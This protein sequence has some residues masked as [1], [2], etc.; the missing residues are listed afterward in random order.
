LA[1]AGAQTLRIS[2]QGDLL[3]QTAGG[4]LRQHR[5]VVYQEV[6][7]VR[8]PVRGGYV[9][10]GKNQIG[11]QVARYDATR[12][13]VIDPTFSYST[14][15]GGSNA[16]YAYGIAVDTAGSAYVTGYTWSTDFPGTTASNNIDAFV[17]KL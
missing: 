4:T 1:I 6:D 15:L 12:P 16:D 14:Y 2:P 17:T 8:R 11:F 7:G 5:P 13:L 10:T 3:L 9:L